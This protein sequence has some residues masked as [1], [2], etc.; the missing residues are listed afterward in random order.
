MTGGG[1]GTKS[2]TLPLLMYQQAFKFSQIGLGT[3]IALVLLCV[4]GLFS[5]FY[6]R[7]LRPEV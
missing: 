6:I 2:Q 4:G 5:A 7:M 3:A 1:P